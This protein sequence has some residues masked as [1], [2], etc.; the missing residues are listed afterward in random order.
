MKTAIVTGATQG[1]GKAIAEKLLAEGMI[2]QE[3][4][5]LITLTD[6]LN[7]VADAIE[8]SLVVQIASLEQEGLDDTKYY[9]T[10][11]TYVNDKNVKKLGES[12]L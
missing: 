3:D 1:I 6:D 12:D 8:K 10:L 7:Y 2:S 9:E 5:E 4:L 11:S